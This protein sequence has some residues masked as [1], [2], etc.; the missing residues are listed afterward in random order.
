M[1]LDDFLLG[2]R[3][4]DIPI[5]PC[6]SLAGLTPTLKRRVCN[7]LIFPLG[8]DSLVEKGF[9]VL[10]PQLCTWDGFDAYGRMFH[11]P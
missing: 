4:K 11:I 8:T 3:Y 7:I 2:Y 5:I 10:H 1:D 6:A 9:P